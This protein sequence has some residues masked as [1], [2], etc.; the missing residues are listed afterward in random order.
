MNKDVL[1]IGGSGFLGSHVC[2]FLHKKGYRVR[3]LD[4]KKSFY[5]NEDYHFI[6][7]DMLDFD[8]LEKAIKGCIYVY[9]FGGI[10]DLNQALTRPIDTVKVNV[11]G[12]VQVLDLCVKYK[13]ER[14]IYSST[15]YVNSREG[16]FY[17][18][19]K[20]ACEEYIEEYSKSYGLNYTILRY[21][22][23]YGERSDESNG[24]YRLVNNAIKNSKVSYIGNVNTKREYINV[25]DA[26]SLSVEILSKKHIN[27]HII[28]TGLEKIGVKDLLHMLN[29]ILGLKDEVEFEDK[30]YLGHYVRTPYAYKQKLI[31]KI[32]PNAYIDFGQ[33]LYDLIYSLKKN[34]CE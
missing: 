4:L 3:I 18:C 7:G 28:I 29:E 16:S 26:A 25:K 11:L 17:R 8:T 33:G 2:D 21:G 19:S 34:S 24:L 30:K 22:S 32:I 23:L 31:K 12:N 15:I 27:E 20:I 10:A 5:L 9:N 14:Y 1:V 13:V 6:K